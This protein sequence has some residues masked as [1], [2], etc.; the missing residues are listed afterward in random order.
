MRNYPFFV[1]SDISKS[2]IDVA[3]FLD[4]KPIYLGQYSNS[5]KG[6]ETM[7][8]VLVSKTNIPFQDWF[9]CF[10]NT[11]SYSKLLLHWLTEKGI[12]CREENPLKISKSLGM[13][14]GKNDKIDS[15]DICRYAFEKRDS[16]EASVL[17][18]PV[19]IKLK[20][21]LSRRELLVKHNKAI[22]TSL[23][24][25]KSIIDPVLFDELNKANLELLNLYKKQIKAIEN[26]IEKLINQDAEIS[27][28]HKLA[29][30]V[31]GIGPVTSAYIIS[32]TNNYK[33]F[34]DPRKFSCYCGVAPFSNS[35]GTQI[36]RKKVNHM[37][38][39]KMKSLF[40]NCISSAIVHD[41]EIASYFKRKKDE[42][43]K[44]GIVLNAVKN[45]LIQ[46]VFAVVK[47]QT[48]YVKMKSYAQ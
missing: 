43:K 8:N 30:S 23:K 1:G 26:R 46:R 48:P 19:V 41:P 37:A 22:K 28:N 21:L 34:T 42:G 35:S 4:N 36:G 7:F 3:F 38:N 12:P 45:K 20:Q 18:K 13:R 17:D 9:I 29:R 27:R 39:K 15:I 10:E 2:V 14:R 5:L 44:T 6:F 16:I 24:E 11:G 40:S 31:I 32:R 33:T 25:Q 47:R